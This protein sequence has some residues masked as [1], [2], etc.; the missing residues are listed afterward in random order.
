MTLKSIKIAGLFGMYDYN[1]QFG[2]DS[3][4]MIL[5]SPN[6]YGK[7]T[8]LNIIN[9]LAKTDLYY[10]YWLNF[11]SVEL[12]FT[13]GALLIIESANVSSEGDDGSQLPDVP[14]EK[15][16]E[17]SFNWIDTLGAQS[18]FVINE[19]LINKAV[20]SIG[21]YEGRHVSGIY[22]FSKEFREFVR[23]N[24]KML[25]LMAR[26]QNNNAFFLQVKSINTVFI[27]AQRIFNANVPSDR[28]NYSIHAERS[29][30]LPNYTIDEV[31]E[32]IKQIL[33]RARYQYLEYTQDKS[34]QLIYRLL[35]DNYDVLS[36]DK[37][38]SVRKE[39]LEKA[40]ELKAYGLIDEVDLPEYDEAHTKEL[41][42]HIKETQEKFSRLDDVYGKVKLF[43]DLIGKKHFT[44]KTIV[45]SREKGLLAV[46]KDQKWLD[47]SDLSSGEQNIIVMLYY[48]VFE[49]NKNKLLLIDEPEISL[50][51]AWQ[52]QY[53][54]ELEE[55][56]ELNDGQA[57][58]A[59]HSPQIIGERWDKCIDLTEQESYE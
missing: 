40:K 4:Y 30:S 59:T 3:H 41:S 38:Q 20:R 18:R 45:F 22:P 57:I 24:P 44:A 51:V 47:L 27:G 31:A 58:I 5:T 11:R 19:K 14:A 37:Y 1:L 46:A 56:L 6:G 50:H 2:E 29:T 21:Y 28:S 43:S 23:Q 32:R 54:E 42:A 49:Y 7:T 39:L 33:R 25:D 17:V 34:N 9:A 35:S 16:R 53:I 10:F 13:E 55:I 8:I 48:L 26:E 36:R 52:Y 12:S 15:S